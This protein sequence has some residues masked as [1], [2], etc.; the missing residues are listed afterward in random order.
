MTRSRKKPSPPTEPT[1][2]TGV[3]N[4]ETPI[5]LFDMDG[6]I[7][8][9]HGTDPAVH[10]RAL[11]EALEDFD[12]E[13][14]A[15]TRS[16]LDGHEYDIEFVRG[17]DRLGVDPIQLFARR[18][19]HASARAIERLRAGHR[20]P[21]PDVEVLSSLSATADLGLVSNNYDA[22]VRSVVDRYRLAKFSHV[23]GRETGVRGF[24]RRKPDPH[25][26]LAGRAALGGR[27]GFYVG[28]RDTDLLAAVRAGLEPVLVRRDHN[29]EVTP[30]VDPVAEIDTLAVLP[31]IVAESTEDRS[32]LE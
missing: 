6:V 2:S 1:E 7:L 28:D 17:C 11:E 32:P 18:E 29:R 8:E 30:S 19:R 24:F 10:Q 15:R 14:D 26:L 16:L 31:R 22:V 9:G 23:S 12:L 13:P 20:T 21:Y 27:T 3:S 4:E 25:Y 5:I